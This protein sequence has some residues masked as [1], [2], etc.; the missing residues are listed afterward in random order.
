MGKCK[1]CGQ[2][3]AGSDKKNPCNACKELYPTAK[4]CCSCGRIYPDDTR[5]TQESKRCDSCSLR[6]MKR[7][8]KALDGE[9]N[10]WRNEGA[11]CQETSEDLPSDIKKVKKQRGRKKCATQKPQRFILK[12]KLGDITIDSI[13]I[14]M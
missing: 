3:E 1:L 5:F 12:L 14:E 2:K 8:A 4:C 6:K 13:P 9:T 7:K 11:D 10:N